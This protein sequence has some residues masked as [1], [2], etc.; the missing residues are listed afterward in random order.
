M[1]PDE[2]LVRQNTMTRENQH[3]MKI[4]PF[5]P[6]LVG[7]TATQKHYNQYNIKC[8]YYFVMWSNHLTNGDKKARSEEQALVLCIVQ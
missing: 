4:W 3:N 6:T 5:A 2:P 7:F 8:N 1:L